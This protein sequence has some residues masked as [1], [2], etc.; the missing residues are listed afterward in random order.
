MGQSSSFFRYDAGSSLGAQAPDTGT[1]LGRASTDSPLITRFTHAFPAR[2]IAWRTSQLRDCGFS[3]RAVQQLVSSN[4]LLR[5]HQGAY[6]RASYWASLSPGARE[7]TIIF[8]HSFGTL[9]CSRTGFVYSH[10]SAARLHRLSLW[11]GDALVH[12]TQTST[13]SSTG[14]DAYTRI[15]KSELEDCEITVINKMRVTTL[16]RTVTDCCLT[17][18]YKK[19]LILTDHALRLGASMAKLQVAAS[20]LGRHRGVRNL[21]KVL[22]YADARSESPGETLTRDLLRELLIEAPTLQHWIHTR[23]GPHRADFAWVDKRVVLEFDGKGKYFDYRPTDQAVFLE[24]KREVALV[25]AGWTVLRIEWKDLFDEASF[26]A[27][28]LATLNR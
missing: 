19:A 8:M 21:R 27:R 11:Q 6:I 18:S 16:E 13:P 24:R 1:V 22:S 10:T 20:R 12:V 7:R 23:Q 5:M 17:M 15:H 3:G 9:S 25:E 2:R 4:V 14:S 26:K 28:I